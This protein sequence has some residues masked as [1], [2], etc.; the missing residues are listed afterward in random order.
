M[1]QSTRNRPR[2]SN[3]DLPPHPGTQEER[4]IQRNS[5]LASTSCAAQAGRDREGT[6]AIP[7]PACRHRRASEIA[8]QSQSLNTKGMVH[9][10][11][12]PV[13]YNE[14]GYG[15]TPIDLLSLNLRC[16]PT[17]TSVIEHY[18]EA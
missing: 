9:L 15:S 12:L 17:D 10:H 7:F 8:I 13:F 11:H 6:R 1:P 14:I 4:T 18:N 16:M 5:R 3:L 2:R